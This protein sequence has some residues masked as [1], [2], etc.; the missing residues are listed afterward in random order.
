MK[1]VPLFLI[2]ASVVAGYA[3]RN[4]PVEAATPELFAPLSAV[5]T[6]P[7][8]RRSRKRS[9]EKNRIQP[10]V[11]R[12]QHVQPAADAASS[13]SWS[14]EASL[15]WEGR[16]N[17]DLDLQTD[18]GRIYYG[19]LSGFGFTLNHDANCDSGSPPEII[20]G[21]GAPGEYHVSPAC[22]PPAAAAATATLC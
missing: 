6:A 11:T 10:L 13:P 3:N 5:E 22:A 1:I 15:S 9:G 21:S 20:T 16:R 18:W 4:K 19:R 7:P 2:I 8:E 17:W 14:L 12:S